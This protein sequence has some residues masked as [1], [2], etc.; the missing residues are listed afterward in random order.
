MRNTWFLGFSKDLFAMRTRLITLTLH[1][2]RR[3]MDTNQKRGLQY[4]TK[5]TN[6]T[7]RAAKRR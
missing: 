6:L 7:W 5:M 1:I 3:L 4:F 2:S